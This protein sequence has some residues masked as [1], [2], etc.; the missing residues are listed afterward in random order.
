MKTRLLLSFLI[1]ASIPS[2][3]QLSINETI[4]YIDKKILETADLQRT[5]NDQ[6]T[7]TL[8]GLDFGTDA[9]NKDKV[10]MGYN[11]KFS[12]NTSDELQ[13]IFD[14]THISS[15]EMSVDSYKD[16]VG[17][18]TVR[19]I[20]KT[21][22]SKQRINGTVTDTN[23]EFF[24]FPYLRTDP[25]NFE[26]LKKALFHLKELYAAKKGPDPFAN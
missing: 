19:M 2:F 25:L 16:A 22:I 9:G 13:Y 3:A 18:I 4:N 14:P 23:K 1:L 8:S 12:D 20:G 5:Y 6:Y 15:V 26:R 21:L 7:Y 17:L 10:I 24:T 11:R